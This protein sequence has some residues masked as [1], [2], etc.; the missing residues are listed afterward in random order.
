MTALSPADKEHLRQEAHAIGFDAV[1]FAAAGDDGAPARALASYVAQGLHGDMA[2]MADT[3]E[4]RKS[5]TALWPEVQ[6]VIALG[7]NY[8]PGRDPLA[9]HSHKDRG[10]ISVYAQGRDYHDVVKKRL[11]RLAR[12]IVAAHPSALKVFVDT[13]PVM[14]KPIAQRAGIGWRGRHTNIV[15]REFGSWLFLGEIFTTL[16]IPPDAPHTDHC[17]Q[18]RLCID[19]CPTQA[20]NV[21]GKIDPRRCVSYLTI[22]TKTSVPEALRGDLGNRIYG[23][24]DC[25]AV[26][27]WNKFAKPAR[28]DAFHPR[29]ELTAPRLAD[30][31]QLDDAQFRALFAGSPVKRSK[32]GRFVRNVLYAIANG[33]GRSHDLLARVRALCA[34]PDPQVGEAARW[35]LAHIEKFP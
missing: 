26:C 11:K 15:S 18:C 21:E 22:E 2:W 27:P 31:I 8:S 14:E 19:A 5:P 29:V 10:A 17:G 1:G 33:D 28:E 32:R 4:R 24:D 35:A 20:L 16:T 12:W 9:V 34:D 25:L 13:A 23:C 7:V 30:L 3:Q 6:S